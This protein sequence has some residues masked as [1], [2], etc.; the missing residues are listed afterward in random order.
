MITFC[1]GV[2]VSL[3]INSHGLGFRFI[4]SHWFGCIHH[5]LKHCVDIMS[6]KRACAIQLDPPPRQK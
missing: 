5:F 3:F 6:S 4:S 1:K 2:C